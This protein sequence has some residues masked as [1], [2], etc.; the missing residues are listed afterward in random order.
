M[1]LQTFGH[2]WIFA[3]CELAMGIGQCDECGFCAVIY[4]ITYLTDQSENVFANTFSYC[5]QKNGVCD[6]KENI[7]STSLV[8]I[9]DL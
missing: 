6:E 7:Y 3:A 4:S 8:Q 2:K 9:D 5:A 1:Y